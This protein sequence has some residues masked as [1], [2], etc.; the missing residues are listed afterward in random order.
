MD[1]LISANTYLKSAGVNNRTQ[2]TR[3]KLIYTDFKSAN[4]C[5][6]RVISVLL[7]KCFKQKKRQPFTGCRLANTK[8]QKQQLL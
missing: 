1:I 7:T 6:I 5:S 4:I 2:M 3:I 8:Q